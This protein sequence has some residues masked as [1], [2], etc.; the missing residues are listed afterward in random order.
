[1][2]KK[3]TRSLHFNYSDKCFSSVTSLNRICMN[4]SERSPEKRHVNAVN[5][6]FENESTMELL[7]YTADDCS[8]FNAVGWWG[9]QS[10]DFTCWRSQPKRPRLLL[11]VSAEF[12]WH[13]SSAGKLTSNNWAK[14]A[15]WYPES[16]SAAC[17]ALKTVDYV[18]KTLKL[19][20]GRQNSE[21][22]WTVHHTQHV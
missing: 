9:Q 14:F 21:R 7:A 16:I 18:V 22:T 10:S 1:M 15:M 5:G 8:M 20:S 19:S 17:E 2:S 13:F 12:K 3:V 6:P 4:T 11:H